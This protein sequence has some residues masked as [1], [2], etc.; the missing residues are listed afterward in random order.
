M[1]SASGDGSGERFSGRTRPTAR[2]CKLTGRG[3]EELGFVPPAKAERT[4]TAACRSHN[5][6]CAL[7]AVMSGRLV[8]SNYWRAAE[9]ITAL[10]E[11]HVPEA[12]E[13]EAAYRE[14]C[15]M[16]ERSHKSGA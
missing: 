1:T 7:G 6:R 2:H 5:S 12:T 13:L 4:A 15:E 10:R 16:P 14:V 3:A 9:V 8:P 11:R